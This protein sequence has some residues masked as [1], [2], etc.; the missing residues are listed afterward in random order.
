MGSVQEPHPHLGSVEGHELTGSGPATGPQATGPVAVRPVSIERLTGEALEAW[1]D[2]RAAH[3]RGPRP[4]SRPLPQW[5]RRL[6]W[7]LDD[8]I[9]VPGTAGRRVGIDGVLSLI[10]G[11]GDAAGFALSMVVVAAGLAA[12]VS[13]PTLARM[14]VNVAAESVI[15]L[16]PFAG[17]IADMAFKANN[18]NLRLIEAD[19]AD[20]RA[21]R[22]SSLTVLVLLVLM[23]VVSLVMMAVLAAAG[24]L[25]FVWVVYRL[26]S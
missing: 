1:H 15:G 2:L 24:I 3:G 17:A 13:L 14:L 9:P 18:R 23:A 21:T 7:L 8:S 20:R 6:A 19:L 4:N 22:R 11:V 16:I 10:P 12:G 26:V 25:I 5:V